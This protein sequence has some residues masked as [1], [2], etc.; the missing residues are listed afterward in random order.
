MKETTTF[1][2]VSLDDLMSSYIK[3]SYILIAELNIAKRIH[4]GSL[5][6]TL[7]PE[8]F[9]VYLGSA[10]GGLKPRVKRHLTKA[11]KLKWHIDHLLNEADVSQVIL[12]E[13]ERRLE[14]LLAQALVTKLPFIPDFGSS[15]CHCKSH[16]YFTDNKSSLEQGINNAIAEVALSQEHF[17]QLSGFENRSQDG[18][19]NY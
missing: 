14:C 3:G 17:K 1:P 12:C 9:Y 6:V 4:V 13:T 11:K 18:K 2:Q 16:L 15:D 8:S 5:G 7:F 19:F 10:L